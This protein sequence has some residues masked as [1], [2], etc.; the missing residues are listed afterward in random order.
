M[1]YFLHY[2]ELPAAL[3]ARQ[4]AIPVPRD[5][6]PNLQDQLAEE[7][8]ADGQENQVPPPVYE[9]SDN[10][11]LAEAQPV[12]DPRNRRQR[13]ENSQ[14]LPH[15][16]VVTQRISGGIHVDADGGTREQ[17]NEFSKE[18]CNFGG[19]SALVN[20]SSTSIRYKDQ[21][22]MYRRSYSTGGTDV[23]VTMNNW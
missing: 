6:Q 21:R 9:L 10:E 5:I 4:G 15:Q 14:R 22:S 23:S 17:Q 12:E 11:D 7:P 16:P 1:L 19:P 8:P 18:E 13:T 3:L 2:W 20:V